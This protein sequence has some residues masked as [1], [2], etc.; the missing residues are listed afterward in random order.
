MG[1][2]DAFKGDSKWKLGL[3]KSYHGGNA[4]EGRTGA[5]AKEAAAAAKVSQAKAIMKGCKGCKK[6]GVCPKHKKEGK[7]I[8]NGGK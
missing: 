4:Y 6:L 3:G 7:I 8:Q 2:K 1:F 5:R